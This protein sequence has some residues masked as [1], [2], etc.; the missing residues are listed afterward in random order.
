LAPRPGGEGGKP[1]YDH[2]GRR[3][4]LISYGG[5]GRQPRG[6]PW[7]P[8]ATC[9][10]AKTLQGLRPGAGPPGAA[11]YAGQLRISR[12]KQPLCEATLPRLSP[13]GRTT[14][15]H[16]VNWGLRILRE[17]NRTW[18][19]KT[20]QRRYP[21]AHVSVRS[22]RGKHRVVASKGPQ[23]LTCWTSQKARRVYNRDCRG[24]S[25]S[26]RPIRILTFAN[27]P[28]SRGGRVGA[29]NGASPPTT[30]AQPLDVER[31]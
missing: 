13:R 24:P 17:N 26:V 9:I 14:R 23:L 22:D 11:Q 20:F 15:R 6:N 7:Q 1:V 5:R 27:H 25:D 12:G 28:F 31:P 30:M 29:E 8:L 2:I 19:G 16:P 21:T 4:G 10:P 18:T 3:G